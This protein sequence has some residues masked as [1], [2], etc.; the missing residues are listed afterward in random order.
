MKLRPG[1]KVWLS[2]RDHDF[3]LRRSL[4]VEMVGR[5]RWAIY[6]NMPVDMIGI[7]RWTHLIAS[8]VEQL[9]LGVAQFKRTNM[10]CMAEQLIAD[11]SM[12]VPE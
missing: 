5:L 8:N 12:E 9:S 10:D 7:G 6:D 1:D 3:C 2:T 4:W 11:G